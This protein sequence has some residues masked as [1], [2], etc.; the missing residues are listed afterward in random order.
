MLVKLAWKNIWRNK[1]RS[2][3]IILSALFGI[4]GGVLS[5]GIF[6][7]MWETTI[8]AAINRELSH[9]Q[10][11]HPNFRDEKLIT[12]FIS[13]PDDVKRILKSNSLIKAYSSRTILEGMASSPNSVSGVKIIAIEPEEEKQITS[14]YQKLI[15][16]EYFSKN[17]YEIL[18]GQKLAERLKLKLNSKVVLSFQGLDNNLIASAFRVVGIFK[19]ESK[20]FDETNVFIKRNDLLP[21]LGTSAPI[22]EFAIRVTSAE[23]IDSAANLIKSRVKNL[24]VE[25]WKEIAPELSLTSGFLYM[26]LNIFMGIIL[27]ALLFGIS[28]TMM[29]SVFERIREFGVLMAIGM[30]RLRLFLLIILESIFLLFSG[31]LI[32]TL[33][34]FISIELLSKNGIDLSIFAEGMA[35]YGMSAILYPALPF[36]MYVTLFVMM[37]I[38]AVIA[39]ISPALKAI[40]LKPA[41]AI[42]TYM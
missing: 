23:L 6:V 27:F 4:W 40:R 13:N 36:H 21:I 19:T 37:M 38:T 31:G 35:A 16:G 7:G 3:I 41:E 26:E 15:E 12:Q 30:K 20:I 34:G 28:N 9:I 22:H 24:K 11:H 1:K 42:R 10:I 25:T 32:G 14:I 17:D 5:N 8:E 39:S 29:M 33:L 18:V 2:L